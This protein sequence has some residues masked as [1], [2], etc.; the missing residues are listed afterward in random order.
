MGRSAHF[1]CMLSMIRRL[2]FPFWLAGVRLLRRRER[3]LLVAAG[4]AA[5]AA[6]LAAVY[7]GAVA[8]QDRDVQH[9][10]QRHIA[11][12]SPVARD[13]PLVLAAAHARAEQAL[14]HQKA[15][16][17]LRLRCLQRVTSSP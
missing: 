14:A 17:G 3:F 12:E 6:M 1:A 13:Q 15:C 4:M 11:D 5:A 9:S 8:A 2:R 16:R 10:R 7:A